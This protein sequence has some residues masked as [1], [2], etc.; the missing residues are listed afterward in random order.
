MI[1]GLAENDITLPPIEG[2]ECPFADFSIMDLA[3][4]SLEAENLTTTAIHDTRL[5][6]KLKEGHLRS[7]CLLLLQV[8]QSFIQVQEVI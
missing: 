6:L 1:S 3:F 5:D 4:L 2:L 7:H 8:F